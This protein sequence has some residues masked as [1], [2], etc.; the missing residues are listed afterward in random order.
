MR[1][2]ASLSAEILY[3]VANVILTVSALGVATMIVAA[4]GR[5]RAW[6]PEPLGIAFCLVFLAIG[7]RAAVRLWTGNVSAPS[8]ALVVVDWLAAAAALAFL[9]LHRRYGVLI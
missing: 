3:Q 2:A 4:V 1:G 9:S 8:V 6:R 7:V 5:R